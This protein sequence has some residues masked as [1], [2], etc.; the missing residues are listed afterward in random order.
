MATGVLRM[1][2]EPGRSQGAGG[3]GGPWPHGH[4][5]LATM[6]AA[7]ASYASWKREQHCDLENWEQT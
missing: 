1:D 3:S 4:I 5:S 6:V 7:V 2:K